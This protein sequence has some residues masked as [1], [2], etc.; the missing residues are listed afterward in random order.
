MCW[1]KR[2]VVTPERHEMSKRGYKAVGAVVCAA[3]LSLGLGMMATAGAATPRKASNAVATPKMLEASALSSVESA[4]KTASHIKPK[5]A[6]LAAQR[7]ALQRFESAI[8]V[9]TVQVK[10]TAAA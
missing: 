5:T 2:Q 6:R 8:K 7:A 3:S 4:M 9:A 10:P 1:A